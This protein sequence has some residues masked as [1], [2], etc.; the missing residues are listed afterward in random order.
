M[1]DLIL[2]WRIFAELLDGLPP[3]AF[4]TP[5]AVHTHQDGIDSRREAMNSRRKAVAHHIPD[6]VANDVPLD[7]NIFP[8]SRLEL[9]DAM[10]ER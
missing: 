8:Q 5:S 9:L 2:G 6:L 1:Q 7:D 3:D 10:P 4:E